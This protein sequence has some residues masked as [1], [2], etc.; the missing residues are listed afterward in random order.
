MLSGTQNE[1]EGGT[2]KYATTRPGTG[3]RGCRRIV[4]GVAALHVIFGLAFDVD[5]IQ[6]LKNG[7]ISIARGYYTTLNGTH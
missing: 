6:A 3:R 1:R 5:N 7:Y 2:L 4:N